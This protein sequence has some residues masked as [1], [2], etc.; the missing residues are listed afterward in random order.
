MASLFDSNS[1]VPPPIPTNS[2]SNR[3]ETTASTPAKSIN[4]WGTIG[5]LTPSQEQAFAKFRSEARESDIEVAKYTVETF[6]QCCL[7]FLRARQFDAEKALILLTECNEKL[8]EMK[9]DYWSSLT[10]DECANCDIAALKNFYP[11]AQSGFD[12]LNR[13]LLF[14][15]TGRMNPNAIL[16]ISNRR[17]LINYHW[18]SM[19]NSLD[20]KFT[21]AAKR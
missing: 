5:N 14:E 7:R 3:I 9:A 8:F 1:N 12:K 19:E 2:S 10:P 16:Q 21:E 13:P 11:H 20:Q 17:N 6:D 4:L 15:H 18:W